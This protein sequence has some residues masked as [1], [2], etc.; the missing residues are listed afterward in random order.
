M[1]GGGRAEI[2]GK[3]MPGKELDPNRQIQANDLPGD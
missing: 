1:P 2:G 3:G